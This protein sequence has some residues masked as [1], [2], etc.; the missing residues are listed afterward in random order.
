MPNASTK[1]DTYD[2]YDDH[3]V[4]HS[5]SGNDYLI[6]YSPLACNCVGFNY[7]QYCRHSTHTLE[8]IKERIQHITPSNPPVIGD[9]TIQDNI[10]HQLIHG[11]KP[12]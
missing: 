7:Y 2:F 3:A 10:M 12:Y 9:T 6:T 11:N 8:H 4:C 1:Q 5:K